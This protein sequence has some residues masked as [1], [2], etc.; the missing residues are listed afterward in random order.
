VAKGLADR[1]AN[2]FSEYRIKT[3]RTAKRALSTDNLV[4]IINLK[5]NPDHELFDTRNFFVVSFAMQGMS[6]IDMAFLTK[7]NIIDGRIR[8]SRAKTG[9]E[10]NIPC[11]PMVRE[12][13]DYY[14]DNKGMN[15]FIFP[16]IKRTSLS[17]QYKDVK[18]S[19]KRYNA[20]LKRLGEL[21][22]IEEKLTSY[23][24]RHTFAMSARLAKVPIDAISQMLG[25]RDVKTTEVYLDS[26]PNVHMDDYMDK[27]MNLSNL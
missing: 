2:P 6:Y 26:I 20:K 12:I 21:C 9:R 11:T 15:D 23:V 7:A 10:Y 22:G 1:D 18:W 14:S 5:L 4:K 8:Y 13:I 24:S 27:I 25:H 19:R 3:E 16:I 17:D